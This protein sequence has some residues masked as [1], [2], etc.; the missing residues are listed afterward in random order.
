MQTPITVATN[1]SP[2][3]LDVHMAC[4]ARRVSVSVGR[5]RQLA[6]T[7]WVASTR[8]V[9]Y[10]TSCVHGPCLLSTAHILQVV[11]VFVCFNECTS[12][13]CGA[14]HVSSIKYLCDVYEQLRRCVTAV[15]ARSS[16]WRKRAYVLR[17]QTLYGIFSQVLYSAVCYGLLKIQ[18]AGVK[19]ADLTEARARLNGGQ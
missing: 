6:P 2:Q 14:T 16:G 8:S 4:G 5:V 18:V 3:L 7:A 15:C 19:L 11:S 10:C 17:K 13:T 1:I 9:K 12:M